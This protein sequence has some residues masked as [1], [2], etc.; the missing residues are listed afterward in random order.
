MKSDTDNHSHDMGKHM[1]L[2]MLAC[3]IPLVIILL[4]PVFGITGNFT[5]IAL[6]VMFAL[7]ILMFAGHSKQNDTKPTKHKH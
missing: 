4:L 6:I 2:M 7:H 3:I 1:W 5:W